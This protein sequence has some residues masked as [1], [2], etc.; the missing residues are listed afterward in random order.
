MKGYDLSFNV[1]GCTNTVAPFSATLFPVTYRVTVN[2]GSSN[3]PNDDYVVNSALTVSGDLSGQTLNVVTRTVTGTV[4]LNGAN[5]VSSIGSCTASSFLRGTVRFFEP[6]N[7]YDLHFS[8]QGCTN[9][10][11]TFTATVFPGPTG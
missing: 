5:P 10:T 8:L 11:A 9:T 1:Q 6:T 2:G 3:L 7:G 4:L